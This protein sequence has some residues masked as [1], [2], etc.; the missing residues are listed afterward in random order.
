MIHRR[1]HFFNS[2]NHHPIARFAIGRNSKSICLLKSI[3]IIQR[4]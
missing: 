2:I 4:A 1:K 3:S